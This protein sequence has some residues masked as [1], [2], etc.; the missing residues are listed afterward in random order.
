MKIGGYQ[1][2]DFSPY[3]ITDGT[4]FEAFEIAELMKV[5]KPKYVSGLRVGDTVIQDCFVNFKENATFWEAQIGDLYVTILKTGVVNVQNKPDVDF[6]NYIEVIDLSNKTFTLG[7]AQ[8]IADLIPVSMGLADK[9]FLIHGVHIGT[10]K[11]QDII[12]NF[13]PTST[14]NTYVTDFH[15]YLMTV[16]PLGA[17]TFS[18]RE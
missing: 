1:I 6:R 18:E 7:T 15:G 8:P 17:T 4:N 9:A 11:Y 16:G 13:E 12:A 2:I 14:V 5:D 3:T 10:K